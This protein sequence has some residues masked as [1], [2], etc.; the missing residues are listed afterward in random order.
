[1]CKFQF[2]HLGV[3]FY[4]ANIIIDGVKQSGEKV[5]FEKTIENCLYEENDGST[6]WI[7]LQIIVRKLDNVYTYK[8]SDN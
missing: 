8:L 2:D 1:M 7:E 6:K 3:G 4:K 5:H